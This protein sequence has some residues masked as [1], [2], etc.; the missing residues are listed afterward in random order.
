VSLWRI[1]PL[2]GIAPAGATSIAPALV[3]LCRNKAVVLQSFKT[4]N[5]DLARTKA[6]SVMIR[7]T[8]V[9][10]KVGSWYG[11]RYSGKML[12]QRELGTYTERVM[13]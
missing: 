9:R 6:P 13:Y 4:V 3:V 10:A 11:K 12:G 8:R 1:L 2:A 5:G 7:S